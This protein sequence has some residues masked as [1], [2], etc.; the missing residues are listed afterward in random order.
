MKKDLN[1]EAYLRVENGT[2]SGRV[3]ALRSTQDGR[4]LVSAAEDKSIAL[5]DVEE[6]RL[7]RRLLGQIGVGKSGEIRGIDITPDDR[8]LVAA[9]RMNEADEKPRRSVLRIYDLETGNLV[10]SARVDGHLAE[11]RLTPDGRQLVTGLYPDGDENLL[12]VYNFQRLLDDGKLEIDWETQVEKDEGP[13]GLTVFDTNQDVRIAVTTWNGATEGGALEVYSLK[14]HR[15][16][17]RVVQAYR[18]RLSTLVQGKTHLAASGYD[19]SR[20]DIFTHDL[21]LVK[22][23]DTGFHPGGLAYSW[24]GNWL[25]V[26]SKAFAAENKDSCTVY[27]VNAGYVV[28]QTYQGHAAAA[29]TVIFVGKQVAASV[30]RELNEIHLWDVASGKSLKQIESKGRAVHGVGLKQDKDDWLVGFSNHAR[31]VVDQ[32]SRPPLHKAFSLRSFSLATLHPGEGEKFTRVVDRQGARW[33]EYSSDNL[34]LYPDG[35]VLTWGVTGWYH[36]ETF[37]FTPDGSVITGDLSGNLR[38]FVSSRDGYT[39]TKNLIGHRA[40]LRDMAVLGDWLATCADDQTICLWYLP[41]VLKPGKKGIGTIEPALNLYVSSD[42]E[43]IVWS[44]SGYYVASQHGDRYIGSHINRGD[45]QEAVFHSSDR[46]LGTLYRPEVIQA[47]LETGSEERALGKLGLEKHHLHDLLPPVIE[48]RSPARQKV[49]R[50]E[51]EIRFEV[52]P[53]RAPLKR[54]WVLLNGKVAW[55]DNS[56][57]IAQGGAFALKLQ[58]HPGLNEIVILAES[59]AAKSNPERL[60][61]DWGGIVGDGSK[62]P[63]PLHLRA[64]QLNVQVQLE[65]ELPGHSA[66][67]RLTALRNGEQIWQSPAI[68]PGEHLAIEV[69]LLP[70]RNQ[71]KVRSSAGSVDL[72]DMEMEA[73][74]PA[75]HQG[76]Q[77]QGRGDETPVTPSGLVSVAPNLYVLAIGV[78]KVDPPID[79]L[80]DLKF[81]HEDA[82]AIADAFKNQQGKGRLYGKVQVRLL[83]DEQATRAGIEDGLAWLENLVKARNEAKVKKQQQ[84]RDLCLIFLAGHGV[85]VGGDYYF[86][87]S[88]F[89]TKSYGTTG[90]R[91]LDFGGRIT[92]LPVEVMVILDTCRSGLAGREMIRSLSPETLMKRLL[93]IN[94]STQFIFSAATSDGKSYEYDDL[95]HGAFTWAFLN[96]LEASDPATMLSLASY[97]QQQV[98]T[99]TARHSNRAQTPVAR[100]Y[101]D[102]DALPVYKK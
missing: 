27:D 17:K 2:H 28:R 38:L 74:L 56:S 3:H 65:G 62:I 36:A 99:Y 42:D 84:A 68:K 23:L 21:K 83:L 93:A 98:Q 5:W 53:V 86:I 95:Q 7:V 44:A 82:K 51:V 60:V 46:F 94:E 89:D 39:Y 90:V 96:G 49:E 58:L 75:I 76:D 87:N 81:A 79:G 14:E 47:I 101:G 16:L 69:P 18:D 50:G 80:P 25:L 97:V 22:K 61:V 13:I 92:S 33:L 29:G 77:G 102:V 72:L 10:R 57:G 52:H 88:G 40:A 63:T 15:R 41:D 64:S 48:R 8:Y 4:L 6:H 12:R 70:G 85:D 100:F 30:D 73:P 43:W 59:D 20:V 32:N 45:D 26:G 19:Q 91:L 11:L 71:I 37:G 24:D 55:Q 9:A 67:T 66:T 78:S 35:D 34:W 54:A 1:V 31:R